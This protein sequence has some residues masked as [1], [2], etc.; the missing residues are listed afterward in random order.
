M[1]FPPFGFDVFGYSPITL[2]RAK[3]GE[4]SVM[5]DR[6]PS[7]S[8]RVMVTNGLWMLRQRQSCILPLR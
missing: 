7:P 5:Q 8:F 4:E 1:A 3:R 2:S 6:D